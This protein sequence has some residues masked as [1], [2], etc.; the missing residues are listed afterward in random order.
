MKQS[1]EKKIE[2]EMGKDTQN[3]EVSKRENTNE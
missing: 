3:M 1:R 2:W